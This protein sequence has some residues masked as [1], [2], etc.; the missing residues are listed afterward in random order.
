VAAKP[1]R[2]NSIRLSRFNAFL[3]RVNLNYPLTALA[4]SLIHN[5]LIAVLAN[6]RNFLEEEGTSQPI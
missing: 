6:D 1:K 2:M 5:S 3:Y 4:N